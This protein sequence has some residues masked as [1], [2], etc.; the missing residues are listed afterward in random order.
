MEGDYIYTKINGN[1]TITGHT[2]SA[3]DLTIP[4]R[5][6][7]IEYDALKQELGFSITLEILSSFSTHQSPPHSSRN[8]TYSLYVKCLYTYTIGAGLPNK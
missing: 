8:F 5:V 2:S 6:K 7:N 3:R 4:S 1:I